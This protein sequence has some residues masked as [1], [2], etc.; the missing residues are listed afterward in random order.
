ML[1]LFTYHISHQIGFF[2]IK[3][4]E[5]IDSSGHLLLVF[6]FYLTVAYYFVSSVLIIVI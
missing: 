1:L 3:L 6:Y 2:I 4:E 5:K